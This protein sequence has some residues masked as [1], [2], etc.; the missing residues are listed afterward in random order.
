MS[1]LIFKLSLIILINLNCS[2]K[3]S[4]KLKIKSNSLR[5]SL[6]EFKIQK[7]IIKTSPFIFFGGCFTKKLFLYALNSALKN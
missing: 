1:N 3:L 2:I 4:N 7:N 5:K 6:I